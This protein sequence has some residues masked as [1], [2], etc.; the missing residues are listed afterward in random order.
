[1]VG[2]EV[3]RTAMWCIEVDECSPK[4]C[5]PMPRLVTESVGKALQITPYAPQKYMSTIGSFP[6]H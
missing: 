3:G 4:L 2:C 6:C 5:S 1:M